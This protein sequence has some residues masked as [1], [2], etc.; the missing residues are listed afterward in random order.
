M[1]EFQRDLKMKI[2]ASIIS[3]CKYMKV[4]ILALAKNVIMI[5]INL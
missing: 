2:I 1:T 5:R 4:S 3:P